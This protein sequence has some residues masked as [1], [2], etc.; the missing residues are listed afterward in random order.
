MP[1]RSP[2]CRPGRKIA[3]PSMEQ[4]IE[5]IGQ[6]LRQ[7]KV[8]SISD[9]A[10]KADVSR[11]AASRAV[12]ELVAKEL[13]EHKAYG[14]VDLAPKGRHLLKALTARH[15]AL[16]LFFAHVLG[17]DREHAD[18]EACRLEHQINDDIVDRLARLTSFIESH[19]HTA[20]E[21]RAELDEMRRV[22][23]EREEPVPD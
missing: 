11:P 6:L 17:L 19:S 14:Y 2:H 15:E 7:G 12:R 16:Y 5:A 10:E 8:C 22:K 4:Y 1:T 20:H 9:I 18:N 23:Q 3:T 21:W 13:V